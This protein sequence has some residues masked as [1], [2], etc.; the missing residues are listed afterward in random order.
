MSVH[1]RPCPSVSV[2]VRPCPSVSVRV[3]P[4]PSVSVRGPSPSG[5]GRGRAR[6]GADSHVWHASRRQTLVAARC[7]VAYDSVQV[8][9]GSAAKYRQLCLMN[10][11]I[12]V[13][14]LV[15]FL[16]R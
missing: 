13:P 7:A 9:V 5:S 8:R 10:M 11:M 2:R 14:L 4:S 15:F 16:K 6:T 12:D 1:V 3:C